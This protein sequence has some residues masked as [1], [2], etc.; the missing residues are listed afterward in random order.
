MIKLRHIEA[1]LMYGAMSVGCW[2]LAMSL[3]VPN[4]PF[5]KYYI[6]ELIIKISVR[7]SNKLLK[8]I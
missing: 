3:F 8:L 6:V 7:I 2:F 4:I 5:W 1:M